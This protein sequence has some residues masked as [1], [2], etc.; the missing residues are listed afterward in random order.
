[1]G[2]Q[3]PKSKTTAVVLAVF[4]SFW[5]WLYT[6]QKDNWKFW[7]GLGLGILGIILTASTGFGVFIHLGVGIWAIIDAAVKPAS[8]YQNFPNG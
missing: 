8:Y 3:P 6:Y 2:S 5:T 1:M 4:L 7:T